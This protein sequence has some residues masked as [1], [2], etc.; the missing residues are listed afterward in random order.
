MTTM[1]QLVVVKAASE[2]SLLQVSSN[3]L[4]GH[5]LHASLE[6]IVLLINVRWINFSSRVTLTSSSDQERFPAADI[7]R[8]RRPDAFEF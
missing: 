8:A 2:L 1:R 4:V 7:L 6:Q 3:V 5:L